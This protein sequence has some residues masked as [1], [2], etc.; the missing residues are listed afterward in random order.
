MPSQIQVT[1]RDLRRIIKRISKGG[2]LAD[3][4]ELVGANERTLWRRRVTDSRFR[5]LTDT[6]L[7]YRKKSRLRPCG[8]FARYNSGCRCAKC[9]RANAKRHAEQR[10][11]RKSSHS[12]DTIPHGAS[13]YVNYG[14]EC[15]V[16]RDAVSERNQLQRRSRVERSE[17]APHGT[18]AAYSGW[19]CRC[20]ECRRAGNEY[21]QGIYSETLDGASNHFK[22]W[23]GPEMEILE[24]GD[25]SH[26]EAALLLGRTVWAVQTM[27]RRLRAEPK[28]IQVVGIGGD[29]P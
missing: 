15:D 7:E 18:K 26:R 3:A 11:R 1:E 12:V 14:C 13:G 5:L 22:K 27:R 17:Q 21:R 6:A 2:T 16:C 10:V 8:T 9:R 19:G 20:A 4:A 24:R 29:R 23:T 25:L 28:V